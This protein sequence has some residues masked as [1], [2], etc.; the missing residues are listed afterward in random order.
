MRRPHGR[1][2]AFMESYAGNRRGSE[3]EKELTTETQRLGE[4]KR[5]NHRDTEAR[6]RNEKKS[7]EN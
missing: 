3:K 4:G 2:R 1:E 6:R 7:R 5:T